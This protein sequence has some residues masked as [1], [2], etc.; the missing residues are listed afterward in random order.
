MSEWT[1]YH[2]PRCSKSRETLARL[3]ERGVKVKVIEYL[4]HPPD[5]T[6]LEELLEKL[7]MRPSELVRRK[8]S[9][10]RE[11]GL[12]LT[13]EDAVLDVL[14][15]HPALIERPIAVRGDRAVLGR[16]PENVDELF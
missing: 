1:I 9:L 10:V 15:T 13:D 14:V 11:I 12:D 6:A 2:N 8:E 16:P 7:A 3:E 4:V 5:R